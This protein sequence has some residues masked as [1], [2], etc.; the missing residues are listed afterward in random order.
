MKK[1]YLRYF[2][3]ILFVLIYLTCR[4]YVIKNMNDPF[5]NTMYTNLIPL[6][7]NVGIGI[8]LGLE[9]F[10]EEIKKEGMWKVWWPKLIFMTIPSLYYS[11]APLLGFIRND[12]VRNIL[13]FPIN[14]FFKISINFIPILQIM[15]GY[16][17]ITGFYKKEERINLNRFIN[18]I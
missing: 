15:L 12:M 16:F 1:V 9:I 13:L 11:V 4:E 8:I 10:V 17:L 18:R 3:Y 2:I 6:L 7:L 14:I 5:E